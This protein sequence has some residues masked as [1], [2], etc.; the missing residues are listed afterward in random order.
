MLVGFLFVCLFI[1][2][3]ENIWA[4]TTKILLREAED[5]KLS[6]ATTN[7][8]RGLDFRNISENLQ[9]VLAQWMEKKGKEEPRMTR[10]N[11]Q[12]VP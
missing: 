3:Q 4:V 10:V 9:E 11:R 8:K 2:P 1:L 7:V 6:H 5:H 12:C